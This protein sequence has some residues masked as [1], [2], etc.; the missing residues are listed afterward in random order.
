M[1]FFSLKGF[2]EILDFQLRIVQCVWNLINFLGGN[3]SF[4]SAFSS[5][6]ICETRKSCLIVKGLTTGNEFLF[7][8][9]FASWF[10]KQLKIC[11]SWYAHLQLPHNLSTKLA[12]F[13][14]KFIYLRW[15]FWGEPIFSNQNACRRAMNIYKI[16]YANVSVYFIY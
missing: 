5:L 7:S 8:L 15:F 4:W 3:S 13:G 16:C 1:S 10:F 11:K 14:A 2:S 9:F 6:V 12:Q